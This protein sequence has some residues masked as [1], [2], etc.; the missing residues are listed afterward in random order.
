MLRTKA[1]ARWYG[2]HWRPAARYSELARLE[3]ADFNPDAGTV[4]IRKSKSGKAQARR[5]D[6]PG[7]CVLPAT[8]PRSC[9]S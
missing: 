5:L 9:R 4:A 1:S 7:H 8:L 3:V 2:P 6:G